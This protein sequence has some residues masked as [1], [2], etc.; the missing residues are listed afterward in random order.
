M[1]K[2][3]Q[4]KRIKQLQRELRIVT[5]A[6]WVLGMSLGIVI[7]FMGTFSMNDIYYA[8]FQDGQANCIIPT[9][10][11]CDNETFTY[12]Y[13]FEITNLFTGEIKYTNNKTVIGCVK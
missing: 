9:Q 2:N 6:Y 13:G 8:G 5:I 11:T 4:N 1:E 7:L 10:I 3:K 12:K